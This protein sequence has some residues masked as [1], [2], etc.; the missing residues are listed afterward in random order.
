MSQVKW[1]SPCNLYDTKD[2]QLREVPVIP[3]ASLAEVVEG[4]KMIATGKWDDATTIALGEAILGGLEQHGR[5]SANEWL[6]QR[7]LAMLGGNK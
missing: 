4:L 3:L 7:L 5:V 6:A 1:V 2:G